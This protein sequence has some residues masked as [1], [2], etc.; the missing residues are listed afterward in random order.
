VTS[1]Q[2]GLCACRRLD[3]SGSGDDVC[4]LVCDDCASRPL[5]EWESYP[6]SIR[7]LRSSRILSR[8]SSGRTAT[9]WHSGREEILQRYKDLQDIIA[10]LGIDE[11]SKR[12]RQLSAGS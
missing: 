7:W 5:S 11:L 9:T 10:I 8:A 6:Q 12:T 1:V 4:S 2:A 3:R